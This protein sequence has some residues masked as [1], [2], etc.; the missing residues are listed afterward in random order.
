[1]KIAFLTLY[2]GVV[3]RGVET[4]VK[5][6]ANRLAVNNEVDV[7]QSGTPIGNEKYQV[8]KIDLILDWNNKDSTLTLRRLFFLDYWSRLIF[9][10]TCLC[11]GSLRKGKYDIIIPTDGGWEKPLCLLLKIFTGAKII[12]SGQSGMGYD[13]LWNLLWRPDAFIA[14]TD[15]AKNWAKKIG[16]GVRVEKIPN[17]VDLDKFNLKVKPLSLKLPHP[18]ILCASALVFSK[19]IDLTIK[20]VAKL[21]NVSLLVVGDG[22]EREKLEKL[23]NNLL[24]GK[25]MLLKAKY[26]EMP[27]IYRSAD[28]FTMVSYSSEAFGIVYVEAMACNLPIV[29]TDDEMRHEIIGEAG[30]F[31]DPKDIDEY[32]KKLDEAL[33]TKWGDKPRIQA[34]KFSWDEIAKKYE[35]VMLEVLK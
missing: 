8:K 20:A 24:P 31:V 2:S 13:E 7:Y 14:L 25:F 1:M 4:F 18:V 32:A 29:A 16:F 11:F 23:G 27:S 22:G 12:V 33:K 21:P 6:L 34:E 28:L 10:F 19:R 5:E 15:K 26:E 17:G 3:N 9:K 35:G 30:L